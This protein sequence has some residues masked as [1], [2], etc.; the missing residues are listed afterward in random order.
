MR[1]VYPV[2]NGFN[3]RA[4]AVIRKVFGKV[5]VDYTD[6][7]L[8][9]SLAIT[10]T[11]E[12]NVSYL[13]HTSDT[14]TAPFAKIASLDGSW[15]LDGSYKLA[16]SP[17]EADTHEM[18]WWGSQLA[19]V[20]GAFIAP[21]PALT[22]AFF[23]RPIWSLRVI[24]D[25][26][27]AEYPVDFTV[28][29]YGAGD[30]LKYTE[31]V[32]GNTL[33][34]W[35]KDIAVVTAVVKSVLEITK[36]SHTG[37][38][39][40]ITEFFTSIQEIYEGEDLLEIKLTEEREVTSGS[41]P[42]GNISANEIS[43]R[44]SNVS[45]KFDAS[46]SSS[47]LYQLIKANRRIKA[48]LGL[49]AENINSA[50]KP[51]FNRA[52]VAY[53]MDGTQVLAYQPRYEDGVFGKALM[54]E[55][56]TVNLVPAVK[57]SFGVWT[58][59]GYVWTFLSS[60]TLSIGEVITIS[61]DIKNWSGT[62][63]WLC[64]SI[65]GGTTINVPIDASKSKQIYTF[66]V[67]IAGA[68]NFYLI[69]WGDGAS[70]EYKNW[71]IE[72]KAFRTSFT[73][74]TRTYETMALP[75][76]V[77]NL[78]EGTI[79]FRFCPLN[80]VLK[81]QLFFV[82]NGGSPNAFYMTLTAGRFRFY[83]GNGTS[84]QFVQSSMFVSA[85]NWY[86]VAVTWNQAGTALYVDGVK[87]AELA[88]IPVPTIQTHIFNYAN[89]TYAGN[90]LLDDLRMSNRARTASEILAAYQRNKPLELDANTTYLLPFNDSLYPVEKCMLPLGTFW[91]GD[92]E[93]PEDDI[94]A[95]TTGLDR[96]ELLRKTNYSTAQVQTD[97]TLYQLAIDVLTDAGLTAAEYWVDPELQ[98]SVVPYSYFASMPHR[99]A[100]RLIAEASLGQVYMD[101]TGIL[102]IEGAS[103]LT[104]KDQYI[105]EISNGNFVDTTGWTPSFGTH[106]AVSNVLKVTGNGS[107][108]AVGGYQITSI[109]CTAGSRVFLRVK[110]RVTNSECTKMRLMPNTTSDSATSNNIN[111]GEIVSP[112]ADEWYPLYGIFTTPVGRTGT[113]RFVF[114]QVYATSTIANGKVMEIKEAISIDMGIAS[115][116]PLYNKTA[117]EINEMCPFVE[118]TGILPSDLVI[119]GDMYFTKNNPSNTSNVANYVE[120]ETQPLKP[121]VPAEV[122]RS[123]NPVSIA[124]GASI[125]LT[126]YY[127]N[128]PCINASAA[129][130][131]GTSVVILAASYYAWGAMITLKNNN[132]AT[133][134]VTLIITATPLQVMNKERAIS[135]DAASITEHGKLKY[136][137]PVN[138]LIQTLPVAQLI[139]DKLLAS[140]KD[141]RRD[142]TIQWRGNP[143]VLLSDRVSIVDRNEQSDFYVTKQDITYAGYLKANL[144]GR[145]AL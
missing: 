22:V 42:V 36:W 41:L 27:R 58:L 95:K 114:D 91:S 108:V 88:F 55:E 3:D 25:S 20:D 15:K 14:I 81:Y 5:Q 69:S 138:P 13:K 99:E 65:A 7:F 87:S 139:A 32:V 123:N 72:K 74:G 19:G 126:V 141:S 142:T 143:A 76:S 23:S 111:C 127:N 56:G 16:P 79:E 17:T 28:K 44:L 21:Y 71:Q 34:T 1:L 117:K 2:S 49:D 61:A 45:R 131:G 135:Q 145:R 48:W 90:F 110:C 109:P 80:Y 119:D 67:T 63:R 62:S 77:L 12:A 29:L 107:H 66:T 31:T 136:T 100:L 144:N 24:G 133:Q 128:P 68:H 104:D 51:T 96:L 98:N 54:F 86:S 84:P 57:Q 70:Y 113:F 53:K 39:A 125:E 130:S 89:D 97:K 132:A 43:V 26:M 85:N 105:N 83:M 134:N 73:T 120:V 10:A 121:S 115:N 8:D 122:Y 9:Q 93:V 101:R 92:W 52:S 37:R 116:S 60:L 140:S 103:F 40:K 50:V 47:P 38:Q 102:R 30:V 106:V 18:G 82:V 59:V 118:D 4:K 64:I 124:S 33:V 137:F 35:S 112:I 75:S 78:T 6:P 46:N 129:I 94:Y 11:E